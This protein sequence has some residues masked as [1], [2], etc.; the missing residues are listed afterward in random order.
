MA[1]IVTCKDLT[2]T[3]EVLRRITRAIEDN[4]VVDWEKTETNNFRYAKAGKGSPVR[5]CPIIRQNVLYFGLVI[6]GNPLFSISREVY[7]DYHSMFYDVLVRLSWKYDFTVEATPHSL[8]DI[9]ANI[10]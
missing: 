3:I 5:F 2:D 7:E 1:L 4:K 10:G 8:A 6:P 9:D